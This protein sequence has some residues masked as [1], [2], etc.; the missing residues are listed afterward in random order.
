M[1]LVREIHD[2]SCSAIVLIGE[3]LLPSKLV[4][5][6]RFHNRMLDWVPAQPADLSDVRHLARLYA[7]EVTMA[8]DLL[9]KIADAASGRVR[10]ACVSIERVREMASTSGLAEVDLAAW[11]D[12]P[13]F[14]GQPPARRQ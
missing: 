2:K 7:P 6:E 11:G 9:G 1:E 4:G 13:L 12:R 14:L 5:W 3:E 10:R 8:D